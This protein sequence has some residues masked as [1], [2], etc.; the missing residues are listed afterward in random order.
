MS[1]LSRVDYRN[2]T[3]DLSAL[4]NDVDDALVTA[5]QALEEFL[6]RPL[7]LATRTETVRIHPDGRAYPLATPIASIT[8]PVGALIRDTA[9]LGL[10]PQQ[11][12]L[13]DILY[14]PYRYG[15]GGQGGEFDTTLP[16]ATITYSGGYTAITLPRK[17]RQANADLARLELAAFQPLTAAVTRATVG[18]VSVAYS[19]PMDRSGAETAIFNQVRGWRRSEI[20]H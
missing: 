12:P 5:Q 16:L 18:D 6:R 4:D 15:P 19:Q 3:G 20:G 17:L 2:M 9:V 11:N 1:L 13:W 7:E 8:D 14:E 10:W